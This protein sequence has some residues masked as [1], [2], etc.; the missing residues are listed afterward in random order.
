MN[1]TDLKKI[2]LPD[3]PGVYRFMHDK[4]ILYIGK[5]TSLRDRVKSYFSNDLIKTRGPRQ[6]LSI[7]KLTKI[8]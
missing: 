7:I 3:T 5:A 8:L 2:N 6:S 4:D 1:L